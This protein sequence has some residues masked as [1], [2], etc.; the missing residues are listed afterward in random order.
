MIQKQINVPTKDFIL[1]IGTSH[2]F[3][4]CDQK[5]LPESSRY[6]HF[7]AKKLG[8]E[9]LSLGYPGIDNL[10]LLQVVNELLRLNVFTEH[11]KMVVLE[12]RFGGHQVRFNKDVDGNPFNDLMDP[13]SEWR[14]M[15]IAQSIMYDPTHKHPDIPAGRS[16][17][18]KMFRIAGLQPIENLR[19]EWEIPHLP[20]EVIEYRWAEE[21]ATPGSSFN[22][23]TIIQS[24]KN[25]VTNINNKQIKFAWLLVDGTVKFKHK[26]YWYDNVEFIQEIYG[27]W[28]DIFDC[29]LI[30]IERKNLPPRAMCE[31]QHLNHVG[32]KLLAN[33]ITPAI[34][35]IYKST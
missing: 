19:H 17:F 20:R 24:I 3:G 33:E 27:E 5:R 32:N 11:C 6:S 9:V 7:V 26:T 12:P 22:D 29:R 4:Q 13:E 21:S 30:W 10:G 25:I 28:L 1:F 23:A 18:D 31:C 15:S 34:T 2:T 16:T 14:N 8:V 35:S